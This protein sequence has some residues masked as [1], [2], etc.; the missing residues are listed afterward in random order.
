MFSGNNIALSVI[1]Q[2]TP[3]FINS[4]P[5]Y[6]YSVILFLTLTQYAINPPHMFYFKPFL[7]AYPWKMEMIIC[8]HVI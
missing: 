3:L 2:N 7:S 6:S 4:F 5:F 1:S 8:V